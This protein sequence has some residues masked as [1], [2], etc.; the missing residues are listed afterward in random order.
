MCIVIFQRHITKML[1]VSKSN[2]IK[3]S[4]VFVALWKEII[5]PQLAT[6]RKQILE[7]QKSEKKNKKNNHLQQC[8]M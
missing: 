4:N 2:Y 3:M 7:E 5:A 1:I 6:E 8:Q